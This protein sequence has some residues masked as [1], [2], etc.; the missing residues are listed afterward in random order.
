MTD[1]QWRDLA[2]AVVAQAIRDWR[3]LCNGG[4]ETKHK[5]FIELEHFFEHDCA[6][7][8]AHDRAAE[9]IYDLLKIERQ[10]KVR[11][12]AGTSLHSIQK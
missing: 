9:R 11:R 8:L 3:C 6:K 10:R 2:T 12:W 7:Y 5:N 4:T 1:D